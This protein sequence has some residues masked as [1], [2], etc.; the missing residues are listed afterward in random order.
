MLDERGRDGN[1]SFEARWR[2]VAGGERGIGASVVVEMA[3]EGGGW[4]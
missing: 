2:E 3:L 4:V 1:G